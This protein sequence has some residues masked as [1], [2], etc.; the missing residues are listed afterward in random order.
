[1]KKKKKIDFFYLKILNFLVVKFSV[2]LNRRVFVLKASARRQR[3]TISVP[4]LDIN[5]FITLLGI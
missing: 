3:K 1:M 5:W 2:Y 4:H